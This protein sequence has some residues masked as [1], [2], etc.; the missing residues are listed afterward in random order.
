MT[1]NFEFTCNQDSMAN[2]VEYF[3]LGLDCAEVCVVLGR[4]MNGED[5]GDPSQV[6]REDLWDP[7]QRVRKM[8]DLLTVWVRPAVHRFNNYLTMLFIVGSCRTSKDISS[9]RVDGIESFDSY[10]RRTIGRR[11]QLGS[12]TSKISAKKSSS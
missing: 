3:N 2:E 11:L 6:V 4:V 5:L 9:K 7:S 10:I 8:I 1:T 12:C